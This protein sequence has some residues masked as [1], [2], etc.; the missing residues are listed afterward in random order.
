MR[1][2]LALVAAGGKLTQPGGATSVMEGLML[3][4][5]EAVEIRVL[6]RPGKSIREIARMLE[7][8][9]NG[10]VR[11]WAQKRTLPLRE[12]SMPIITPSLKVSFRLGPKV[13]SPAKTHSGTGGRASRPLR[14]VARLVGVGGSRRG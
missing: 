5:E 3:V 10:S 2:V 1:V 11:F 6:S 9:R 12:T 4:A 8:S 13:V 7:V 14:I